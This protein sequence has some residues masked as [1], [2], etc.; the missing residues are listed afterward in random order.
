M[1][2]K[3][4]NGF[5]FF[6]LKEGVVEFCRRWEGE[7]VFVLRFYNGIHRDILPLGAFTF[8]TSG[9]RWFSLTLLHERIRRRI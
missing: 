2:T 8:G 6:F 5:A 7:E 1:C 9:P 4:V 3:V